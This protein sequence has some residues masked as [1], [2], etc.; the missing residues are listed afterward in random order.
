MKKKKLSPIEKKIAK[1]YRVVTCPKC[2]LPKAGKWLIE[3]ISC[4]RCH[5]KKEEKVD[6]KDTKTS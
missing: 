4:G 2:G 6:E 1:G 5:Y 3:M